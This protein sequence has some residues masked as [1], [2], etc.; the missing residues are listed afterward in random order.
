MKE[1]ISGTVS[2]YRRPGPGRLVGV[3]GVRRKTA[4]RDCDWSSRLGGPRGSVPER[5]VGLKDDIQP[6][7]GLGGIFIFFGGEIAARDLATQSW[8]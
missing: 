4:P 1:F 5:C 8:H 6:R 2:P 3:I 7:R